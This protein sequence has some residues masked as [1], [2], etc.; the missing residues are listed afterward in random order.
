MNFLDNLHAVLISISI[1]ILLPIT[2]YWGVSSVYACPNWRDFNLEYTQEPDA[3]EA[4]NDI[5]LA[6]W[7]EAKKPFNKALFSTATLIGLLL[8]VVGSYSP[9]KALSIG[10]LAGG[11]FTFLMGLTVNPG[12][13]LL[14]F[15]IAA[16]ILMII[17]VS[18]MIQ[19]KS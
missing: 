15:V 9:I 13:A 1:A 8:I 19:R 6:A 11:L 18:L 16:L 7:E 14:N 10:L 17:I 4:Q 3:D 12:I 5:R 2:V